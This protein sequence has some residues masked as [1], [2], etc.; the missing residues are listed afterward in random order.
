M[1][2][3]TFSQESTFTSHKERRRMSG[4]LAVWI[5]GLIWLPENRPVSIAIVAWRGILITMSVRSHL[6]L[7]LRELLRMNG[8]CSHHQ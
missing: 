7:V 8:S 6:P 3:R 1:C 5:V 4:I 2:S